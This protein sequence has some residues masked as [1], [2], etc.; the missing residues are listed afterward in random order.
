MLRTVL[1]PALALG[2]EL[3]TFVAANFSQVAHFL[4]SDSNKRGK[5]LILGLRDIAS[6]TLLTFLGC[7]LVKQDGAAVDK[8]CR[9]VAFIAGNV[10]VTAGKWE[11][12]SF[13]MVERGRN[14]ALGV[15][16]LGARSLP[17]LHFE[18]AAVRLFVTG[19]TV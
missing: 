10:H 18:L 7:R 11:R 8:L 5:K 12:R 9:R 19:L 4:R 15:V 3:E 13:V 6:V 2:Q 16:A 17:G 1:P 14:P